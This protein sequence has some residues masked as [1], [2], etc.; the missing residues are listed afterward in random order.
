MTQK[1]TTNLQAM[2]AMIKRNGVMPSMDWSE[3]LLVAREILEMG[4]STMTIEQSFYEHKKR[5]GMA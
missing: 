4:K 3:N 1:A 5:R 2:R